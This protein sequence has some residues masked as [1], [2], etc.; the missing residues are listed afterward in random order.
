MMPLD[1][2]H[3]TICYLLLASLNNDLDGVRDERSQ[4]GLENES[5]EHIPELLSWSI[6]GTYQE[7]HRSI[8][9]T[10]YMPVLVM[11]N[12]SYQVQ[13]EFH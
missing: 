10:I 2:E 5:L 4:I 6:E 12:I 8:A 11:Y 9:M 13:H 3:T 1:G 7:N